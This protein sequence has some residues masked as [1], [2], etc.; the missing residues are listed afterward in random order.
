MII[1]FHESLADIQILYSQMKFHVN[2]KHLNLNFELKFFVF[3]GLK[4]V[5][6]D[7]KYIS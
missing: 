5:H 6:L 3:Y 1:H 2:Y 4:L 7:H